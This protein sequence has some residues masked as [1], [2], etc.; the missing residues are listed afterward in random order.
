M[1]ASDYFR[2][3]ILDRIDCSRHAVIEA[4]AGTGKTFTIAHLF[5]DLLIGGAAVD[6]ILAVTYTEKATDELRARIRTAIEDALSGKIPA[7]AGSQRKT[8]SDEDRQ[9]LRAALFGFDRAAIYTIHSFCQRMLTELAF[10]SGIKFGVEVVDGKSAFHDAFRAE[11]R[12]SLAEG[13]WTSRL[14]AEWLETGRYDADRLETFLYDAHRYR[15]LESGAAERI[16]PACDALRND[17]DPARIRNELARA[18]I[19]ASA[20]KKAIGALDMVASAIEQ[21]GGD[22]WGLRELLSKSEDLNHLIEAIGKNGGAA[23]GFSSQTAQC[24]RALKQLA[25]TVGLEP[26]I[27]DVFLDPVEKRL[28]RDK[29]ARGVLDYDDMLAWLRKAMLDSGGRDLVRALRAHFHFALI[30]EFQDTDDIQWQ[31]FHRLFLG[32]EAGDPNILYVIGDPKQAIYS[33]RGADVITYCKAR[34]ELLKTH[35]AK[36]VEL[37]KNFRSTE[38]MLTA[39]NSLL[40]GANAETNFGAEIAGAVPLQAGR[41]ELCARS[42]SGAV[43]APLTLL[44]L[45]SDRKLS[46]TRYREAMGRK[47]AASL[48]QL[49]Y[50]PHY[51]IE[52]SD[53]GAKPRIVMPSGVRV[54]TRTRAESEEIGRYLREA[55]VPT[56]FYRQEGL[57][58]SDEADDVISVLRAIGDPGA[59]SRRLKAWGTPFF[60]VAL[61][62]LPRSDLPAMHSLMRRLFAWREMALNEKFAS[63]F[64]SMLYQSGLAARELLLGASRRALSN[65]EQICELLLE[66]ASINNLDLD[67]IIERLESWILGRTGP[68]G[69]NS[70]VQRLETSDDAVQISTLHAVKGLEGDVVALFGGFA[71]MMMPDLIEVFHDDEEARQLALG[72]IAQSS[73]KDR[74]QSETIAEER[75]L[76]YVAMTRARAKLFLPLL[77]DGCLLKE[78]RGC[79]RHLNDR[80]K[81]IFSQNPLPTEW[82]ELAQIEGTTWRSEAERGG[83]SVSELASWNP[84]AKLLDTEDPD[85]SALERALDTVGRKSAALET[86]SYTSINRRLANAAG[87][88]EP[89]EFKRDLDAAQAADLPGGATVGIF[90]H[91]LIERI[92]LPVLA[93]ARNLEEWKSRPEVHDLIATSIR[94]YRISDGARWMDRAPEIVFNTMRSPIAA[95]TITI[96]ALAAC[97]SSREMEFTFPIPE[98]SHPKLGGEGKSYD[99]R[100]RLERGVYVGFVDFV[101]KYLGRTYFADWKSDSLESYDPAATAAHTLAHYAVQARIYTAGV[102]RLLRIRDESDYETRFGGLLYVFIRGV[103]AQGGGTRAVHFHRPSWTEVLRSERELGSSIARVAGR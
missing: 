31:I 82:K 7:N 64:D 97:E 48:R 75:R 95:G 68:P 9:K 54:L 92:D 73:V 19:S 8:L 91:E 71:K 26:R 18:A 40:L 1:P 25:L 57:F 67:Q 3:A 59:R 34:R 55:G 4:S 50:D 45:D 56:A 11:M 20:R 5:V 47:I 89:P 65:Y 58:A 87:E 29:R 42:E 2:P 60:G 96:P 70:G 99:G 76:L 35:N 22:L 83:A 30:D 101:F 53:A 85:G 13:E 16:A 17:F 51:Q 49:L 36:L 69:R 62:D 32:G 21:A 93:A 88:V 15:Y 63:L 24:V 66:E 81:T 6:Q 38:P 72:S 52:I 98:A 27:A 44:R 74:I 46:A 80:L 28:F 94:R 61:G 33:F 102:L 43:V 77:P 103:S 86:R 39:I 10:L 14:L 78:L 23:K 37:D 90:L 41:I 12:D 100:W 79:Y 84:P